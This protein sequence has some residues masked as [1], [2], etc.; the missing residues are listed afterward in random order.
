ME[1]YILVPESVLMLKTASL[2]S[3]SPVNKDEQFSKHVSNIVYSNDDKHVKNLQLQ[4][5]LRSYLARSGEKLEST[6]LTKNSKRPKQFDPREIE[7]VVEDT[8]E[9]EPGAS[10]EEILKNLSIRH[11]WVLEDLYR[12]PLPLPN[13]RLSPEVPEDLINLDR[14][15]SPE[16]L[17]G[18]ISDVF[19]ATASN[20]EELT[21]QWN[22]KRSSATKKKN[23]RLP[24]NSSPAQTR[25]RLQRQLR[26]GNGRVLGGGLVLW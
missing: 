3:L 24:D 18:D 20:P 22:D 2:K 8:P 17:E 7:S 16:D 13:E 25:S 15:L 9:F 4:S 14:N 19:E 6:N 11:P 10:N 23:R 21:D 1:T 26:A 5:T 12:T